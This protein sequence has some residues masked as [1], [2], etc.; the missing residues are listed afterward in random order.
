MMGTLWE[1]RG[2]EYKTSWYYLYTSS[3]NGKLFEKKKFKLFNDGRVG[4]NAIST[5]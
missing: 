4:I 5:S 1:A 2:G 3:V